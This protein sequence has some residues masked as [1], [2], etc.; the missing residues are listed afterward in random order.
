M[1]LDAILH[2][3]AVTRAPLPT[4]ESIIDA[5]WTISR[6][7]LARRNLWRRVY[8]YLS[9]RSEIRNRA[10]LKQLHEIDLALLRASSQHISKWTI[11]AIMRDWTAYCAASDE[12]RW[13][14]KAAIGAEVRLLYPML[15]R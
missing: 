10:D 3:E 7:S 5:R 13:K 1:L 2:M 15:K 11:D 14:M 12:I 8:D 9:G 4:K 6:K